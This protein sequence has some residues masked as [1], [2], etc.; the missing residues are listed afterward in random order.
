MFERFTENARRVVVLAQEESRLLRHHD[1]RT[2]HLLLGLL[3]VDDDVAR[4]V[5]GVTLAAAHQAVAATSPPEPMAPSGHIP[6]TTSAKRAMQIASDE[7]SRA[8][9]LIGPGHLLLGLLEVHDQQTDSVLTSL[10]VDL[11]A[12][13]GSASALVTGGA[14][15]PR[16]SGPSARDDRPTSTFD[17]DPDPSEGSS[18]HHDA[19]TAAL[20]RYGRHDEDCPVPASACTCG[21][22][23]ALVQ[24]DRGPASG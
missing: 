1:I 16:E 17:A 18:Q 11:D 5:L 23:A 24:A 13:D 6:F 14:G 20:H 2:E 22:D 19:V 12:A 8:D 4:T 15:S 3:R 10:G 21:L 7:A 9:G